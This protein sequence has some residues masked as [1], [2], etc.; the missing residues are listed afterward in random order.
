MAGGGWHGGFAAGGGW[1]L[2]RG[3]WRMKVVALLLPRAFVR[4]RSPQHSSCL[5]LAGLEL[6]NWIPNRYMVCVE[7][8]RTDAGPERSCGG[9]TQR[10]GGGGEARDPQHKVNAHGTSG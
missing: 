5:L 3:G 6:V 9:S 8:G 7:D 4:S 10:R 2:I 1:L